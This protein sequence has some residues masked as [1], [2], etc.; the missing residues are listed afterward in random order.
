MLPFWKKWL[1]QAIPYIQGPRVL[2]ISFGT[3]YLLT[4][5]AN[6]FEAYGLDYNEKLVSTARRNLQKAGFSAHLQRADAERLPYKNETF[7]CIVN[8]MAFTGYPDGKRAMSE[9]HRVLKKGGRLV[10]VD[11]NYPPDGRWIGMKA[12][13]FWA[14][15]GDI[16]RD[17]DKV[18]NEFNFNFTQHT[19]G[20]FGSVH[21]YLAEKV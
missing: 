3:G 19:I 5:Y 10:M 20:G 1:D 7:D 8:T 16:I 13:N 12:V 21:L 17:M 4:R 18:F 14:I 6:R 2:E 9:I 15:L 11:I